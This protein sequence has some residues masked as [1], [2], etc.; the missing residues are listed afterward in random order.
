LALS[1][2]FRQVQHV[3]SEKMGSDFAA[4]QTIFIGKMIRLCQR[5]LTWLILC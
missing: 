5:F 1:L 4:S 3:Y 2:F